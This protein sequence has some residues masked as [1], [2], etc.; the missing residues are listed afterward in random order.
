LGEQVND[1]GV[2]S[3][4]GRRDLCSLGVKRKSSGLKAC[5]TEGRTFGRLGLD[6]EDGGAGDGVVFEGIEG[7]IGFLERE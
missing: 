7:T 2:F 6:F 3:A 5:A 1:D 4:E